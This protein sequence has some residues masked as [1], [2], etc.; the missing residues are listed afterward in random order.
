MPNLEKVYYGY[1]DDNE[2]EVDDYSCMRNYLDEVMKLGII[3]EAEYEEE[4]N[5]AVKEMEGNIH[6]K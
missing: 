5:R 4:F 3:N 6:D 1:S 2:E